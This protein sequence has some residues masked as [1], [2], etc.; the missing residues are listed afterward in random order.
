MG[1]QPRS[2]VE[3]LIVTRHAGITRGLCCSSSRVLFPSQCHIGL[4]SI[5]P[6]LQN[7]LHFNHVIHPVLLRPPRLKVITMS[8]LRKTLLVVVSTV[9]VSTV[10]LYFASQLTLLQGYE[11][12]EQNDRAPTCCA[13]STATSINRAAST[14]RIGR[15]PFGM[16]CTGLSS[17]PI[18][19]LWIRWASRPICL[20]RTKRI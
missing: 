9:I 5:W 6:L 4:C 12:I 11:K 13:S 18:K 3:P 10:S 19:P 1:G 7:T 14:S 17:S 2:V 20:P 16:T 8:L 15:M